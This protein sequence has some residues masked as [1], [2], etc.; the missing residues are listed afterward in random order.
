MLVQFKDYLK[1]LG[2]ATNYYM[3]KIDSTK[4]ETLGIYSQATSAR[5]E[6]F[7]KAS[8]YNVAGF[9]LLVH[10]NKNA[11]E[12]ENAARNVYD[13]IK[14]ITATD[15]DDI[16]VELITMDNGEPVFIGTDDNGVYEYYISGAIYYKRGNS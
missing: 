7:G 5:V 9:R 13:Q 3:G 8:S 2:L 15:M 10:W 16:H 1:T 11:R 4:L 6:A 12:T 14:Y